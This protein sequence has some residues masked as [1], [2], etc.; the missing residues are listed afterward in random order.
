MSVK[1]DVLQYFMEHKGEYISG[2]E[3]AVGLQVSRS[4]IWK[5]VKNLQAEGHEIKAV[6]NKGYCLQ[7]S[8]DVL[9]ESG[10]RKY[11]SEDVLNHVKLIIENT[12]DS[13]NTRLKVMAG[14]GAEEWTVMVAEEQTAGRG[15]MNRSFYSPSRTGIYMSILFRPKI[16]ARESLFITTMAAVAVTK[17]L[18]NILGL[19]PMI[20]WVNDIYLDSKKVCGILTEAAINV[21]NGYLDYA[22]L[23]IGINVKLPEESFPDEI[24]DIA[25]VLSHGG[26]EKEELRCQIV[27]EVLNYIYQYYE[28]LEEHSFMD[29]YISH[30][31]LIGKKVY[32]VGNEQE[33][34]FVKGIS[35]S[36]GLIVEHEDGRVEELSSG[37]VSVKT[38]IAR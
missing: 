19:H 26:D 37:E 20:K 6:T 29:E 5:A 35:E 1:Q 11:M 12:V 28:D 34:L 15:R 31:F 33:E 10:I 18:E 3:L 30:S 8:H 16:S 17:A 13:T 23:G 2:E 38:V 7:S 22:V 14:S 27:A 32:V 21:E 25:G 24:K 9:S 4:A 36:A